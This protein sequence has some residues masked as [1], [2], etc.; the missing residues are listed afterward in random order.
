MFMQTKYMASE[1]WVIDMNKYATAQGTNQDTEYLIEI[2]G[3]YLQLNFGGGSQ[4]PNKYANYITGDHNESLKNLYKAFG[5]DNV[6]VEHFKRGEGP[7]NAEVYEITQGKD[8]YESMKEN[9][10][11]SLKLYRENHS[12]ENTINF[13]V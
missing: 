1:Q 2:K 10:K 7:T 11:S 5:K 4:V 3:E 13:R 8:F 9:L 12:L 6:S